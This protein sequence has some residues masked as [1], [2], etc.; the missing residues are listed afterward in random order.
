MFGPQESETTVPKRMFKPHAKFSTEDD[1][2][3]LSAVE[4]IGLSD[5]ASVAEMVPGKNQRQCCERWMYYVC[6]TLKT[7]RWTPEEDQLLREKQAA[8]GNKWVKIARFFPNRTDA[9]IKNRFGQLLRK[10]KKGKKQNGTKTAKDD[11]ALQ[12]DSEI[13]PAEESFWAMPWENCDVIQDIID[14]WCDEM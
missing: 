10:D 9:M 11:F 4:M 2:R 3:L 5:W 8:I 7:D 12:M 6:P 13:P 14:P 1:E